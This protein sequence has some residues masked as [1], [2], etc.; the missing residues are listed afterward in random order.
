MKFR[1]CDRST[2]MNAIFQRLHNI[3]LLSTRQ[4]S[5]YQQNID[6]NENVLDLRFGGM[7]EPWLE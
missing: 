7:N 3:L 5:F 1:K 4:S 2:T 6:S